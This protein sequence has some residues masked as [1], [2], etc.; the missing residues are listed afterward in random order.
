[1]TDEEIVKLGD[2]GITRQ[3]FKVCSL[4]TSTRPLLPH[5]PLITGGLLQSWEE[6]ESVA[7]SLDGTRADSGGGEKCTR[8][9]TCLFT[10]QHMVGMAC[11]VT[12]LSRDLSPLD[13]QV[14]WYFS[15]GGVQLCRVAI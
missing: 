5:N 7:N 8:F 11:M 2:Y 1:M 10:S 4:A 13:L 15:V 6:P 3:T 9:S 14:I 12:C